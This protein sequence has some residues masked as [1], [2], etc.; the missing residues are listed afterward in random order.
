VTARESDGL[1]S[2]SAA[3]ELL[4]CFGTEA[5]LGPSEVARKLGIAKSTAHRLLSTLCAKGFVDQDPDTGR[6]RLGLHVFELGHLAGSRLTMRQAAFP[7]LRTLRERTGC[8]VHLAVP[9]GHEVFYLERLETDEGLRWFQST[10][11]RQPVHCTSTGK[12]I[13]AFDP[14]SA[15]A[16]V[17]AGFPGLTKLSIRTASHFERELRTVNDSGY[18]VNC[19]EAALGWYSVAAPVLDRTGRARAAVSIVAPTRQGYE[20]ILRH[21]PMANSTAHRLAAELGI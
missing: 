19:E 9:Y 2:V 3:L 13:A 17:R 5:E 14:A 11:W 18:A 21:A 1:R 7:L 15:R 16:R 20:R 12:A 6:Y 8:S 4:N 10:P